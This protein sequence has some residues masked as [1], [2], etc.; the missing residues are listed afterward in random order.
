MT[1]SIRQRFCYPSFAVSQVI[2]LMVCWAMLS[3]LGSTSEHLLQ[4]METL[5]EEIFA[6][7]EPVSHFQLTE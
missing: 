7:S 4:E 1:T 5:E 2:F 6:L 3:T